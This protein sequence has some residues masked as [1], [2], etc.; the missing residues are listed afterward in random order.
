MFAAKI[1]RS[2]KSPQRSNTVVTSI[3]VNLA[4]YINVQTY[5]LTYFAM[6]W[7]LYITLMLESNELVKQTYTVNF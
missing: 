2:F 1:D 6:G 7:L 5:L 3:D 4:P